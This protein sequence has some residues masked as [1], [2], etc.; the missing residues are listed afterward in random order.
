MVKV[1]VQVHIFKVIWDKFN[2]DRR[3]S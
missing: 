3:C 2:V 1:Q